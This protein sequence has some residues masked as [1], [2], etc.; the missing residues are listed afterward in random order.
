[1]IFIYK[2]HFLYSNFKKTYFTMTFFFLIRT[3]CK[4]Q[5]KEIVKYTLK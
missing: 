3:I 1:M 4:A 2:H 5:V